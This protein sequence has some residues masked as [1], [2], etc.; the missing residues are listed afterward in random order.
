MQPRNPGDEDIV[1]LGIKYM[2][3]A[4]SLFLKF[5]I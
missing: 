5:D 3:Y 1:E 4:K 2:T